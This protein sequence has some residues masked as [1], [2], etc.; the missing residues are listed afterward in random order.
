LKEITREEYIRS[1]GNKIIRYNPNEQNFD[2][3][4]VLREINKHL[5]LKIQT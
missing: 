5:F 1:L 3:S 4:N 2:L